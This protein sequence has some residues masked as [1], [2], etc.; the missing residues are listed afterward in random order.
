[1][2]I[3][4]FHGYSLAKTGLCRVVLQVCLTVLGEPAYQYFNNLIC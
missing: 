1:M 4:M 2:S 3:W